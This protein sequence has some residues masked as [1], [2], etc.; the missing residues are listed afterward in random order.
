MATLRLPAGLSWPP[1]LPPL[2]AW[3]FV[4]H[5]RTFSSGARH[6]TPSH[7]PSSAATTARAGEGGGLE[8]LQS[9]SGTSP[10]R[11][12]GFAG[13]AE[14]GHS[15]AGSRGDRAPKPVTRGAPG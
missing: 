5:F 8:Q 4:P 10:E 11:E 7:T 3:S 1:G 2:I 6:Q 9:Y 15:H 13:V 12:R 14:Q